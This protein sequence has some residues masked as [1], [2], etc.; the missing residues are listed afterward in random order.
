MWRSGHPGPP[1]CPTPTQ[2]EGGEVAPA[3]VARV[4]LCPAVM[5]GG[6]ARA[7][8][9][10]RA[11]SVLSCRLPGAPRPRPGNS[12]LQQ[13][14][15]WWAVPASSGFRRV[16]TGGECGRP[17]GRGAGMHRVRGASGAV[18]ARGPGFPQISAPARPPRPLSSDPR[19]VRIP[20]SPHRCA[21]PGEALGRMGGSGSS[22]TGEGGLPSPHPTPRGRARRPAPPRRRRCDVDVGTVD[23][24]PA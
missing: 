6:R 16:K 5:E 7:R 22:P 11:R 23:L 12:G 17:R 10:Q 2:R 21:A 14:L 19:A 18:Q 3:R 1:P 4:Q 20:S 13:F 9:P 24:A 15:N 8:D